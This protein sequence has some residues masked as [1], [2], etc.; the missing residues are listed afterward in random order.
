MEKHLLVAISDDFSGSYSVKFI[1]SFLEN[2]T[3]VKV[4]LFY[5][6]PPKSSSSSMDIGDA[7]LSPE[8]SPKISTRTDKA[9]A[10]GIK[11]L[12]RNGFLKEKIN[13][14]I[15]IRRQTKILDIIKEGHSGKYDAVVLGRRGASAFEALLSERVTDGILAQNV[16][17]PLWICKEP[18]QERQNILL[19]IDGSEAALRMADHVG[20]ILNRESR[21][22]VTE[23][24]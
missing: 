18:G 20:Y 1:S 16:N 14:K 22:R 6:A 7:W 24:V 17:F 9:F 13:T 10:G 8:E 11:I 4:T 21:H 5:V 12:C 2:K 23:L 3:E 15:I 19:C